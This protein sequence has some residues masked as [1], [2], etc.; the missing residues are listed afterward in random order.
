MW[1][2]LSHVDLTSVYLTINNFMKGTKWSKEQFS[3]MAKFTS[4]AD[5]FNPLKRQYWYWN[6]KLE[7]DK[8]DL[9]VIDMELILIRVYCN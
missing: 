5:L 4:I 1:D 6:T 7:I 2:P 3:L 8:E 9:L